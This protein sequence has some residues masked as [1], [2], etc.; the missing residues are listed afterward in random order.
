M[1]NTGKKGGSK[2]FMLSLVA[3]STNSTFY[4]LAILSIVATPSTTVISVR[5]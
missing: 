1:D 4:A 2:A 5:L 3:V